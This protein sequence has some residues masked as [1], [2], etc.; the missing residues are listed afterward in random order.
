ML[1][2]GKYPGGSRVSCFNIPV[3]LLSGQSDSIKNVFFPKKKSHACAFLWISVEQ[4]R[5]PA[6][7]RRF[8]ALQLFRKCVFGL[9]KAFYS[10]IAIFP[11][12]ELFPEFFLKILK[13]RSKNSFHGNYCPFI[14]LQRI[15][16]FFFHFKIF[17]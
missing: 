16:C 12:S 15:I 17:L 2:G 6:S 7:T 10:K 9:K 1:E 14:R 11:T 3:E 5:R 8:S 4:T 13:F